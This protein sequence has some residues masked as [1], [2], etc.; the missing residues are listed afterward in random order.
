MFFPQLSGFFLVFKKGK[1]TLAILLF[2]LLGVALVFLHSPSPGTTI[3]PHTWVVN[4]NHPFAS[5]KSL[6]TEARPFKTIS[7]AAEL[8]QP[9][10]TV[11][12]H[13]GVY[14]ERIAPPR[15]GKPGLPIIYQAVPGEE[16]FVR[17]SELW[18][19]DPEPV[20]GIENLYSG[21]LDPDIFGDYNPFRI[22]LERMGGN[23]TL[24]Q[25]F[26]EG[27]PLNEVDTLEQVFIQPNSWKFDPDENRLY[28][29]FIA[30]PKPPLSRQI[31]V[32]VR[33]RIFAPHIRG[34]GYIHV[35][36]FIFEHAA[37]QFPSGFWANA[38]TAQAGAVGTR[39]GHHW[40]IEN[41]VIR[42]AKSIGLDCGSESR[43]DLEGDQPTPEN[44]GY[45]VI[46]N[47]IIT[48]NGC[49]GIAG[50]KHTGTQI[51][52]NRIERNNRLG[53]TAPEI[54]GIKVHKFVDGVIEGNLVRDNDAFGI[55]VDN[56]YRNSRVSRNVVINNQQAGIF[57]EMGAGPIL[58]DNNIVAYTRSGEGIYTHDAS[59]VTIAHNLLYVNTHFGVYMRTVT[60]RKFSTETGER[61][62]VATSHQRI[63]NNI[64]VDNYRGNIS[65]PFPSERN[66]DN[67]SDYNLFINGTRWHW[68]GLGLNAFVLNTS[69]GS[70]SK[71]ELAI[72]LKTALNRDNLSAKEQPNF[73]L[74]KEQP[75]L[76][77][78]WW[79]TL[80]GNDKHSVFPAVKM[81][82][83]ENGAIEKGSINLAARGLYLEL[84]DGSPFQQLHPPFVPGIERDFWGQIL[85]EKQEQ[86]LAGPFQNLSS[87]RNGL[88]LWPIHTTSIKLKERDTAQNSA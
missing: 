22:K 42:Y 78:E 40:V 44:V 10:D 87:E 8:A 7:K 29:H 61:E 12:V 20:N 48:D 59:G 46:K 6:G 18:K 3:H 68:E 32:S 35:K 54:G 66:F 37:N 88:N 51:I 19:P 17:G 26:V 84:K 77:F 47:N 74:W 57:V 21:V 11:L 27:K 55:W 41:N 24:G 34:L 38:E 80:T 39:S 43:F 86:L 56:V 9:G 69:S 76:T 70:R 67:L 62:T 72:A 4:Q 81:G 79:K 65:L 52:G 31:E 16:V 45:H 53:W 64:F 85:P 60:E 73:R 71:D 2:V 25:V 23:R 50:W 28:V 30:E 13:A 36:G 82:E 1:N 58:V 5:N 33:Q 83:I 15:G 49:C 75:Y 14:R 63:Y